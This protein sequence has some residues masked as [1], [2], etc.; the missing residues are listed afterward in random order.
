MSADEN[1]IVSGGADSLLVRWKDVTEEKKK[2]LIEEREKLVLQEQ[3]L[4]NLIHDGELLK[5]L[6]MAL[7]LQRPHQSLNIVRG[8][9]KRYLCNNLQ[10][11]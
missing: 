5:A 4:A 10:L 1:S 8:L 11:T 6:K 7:R 9:Y 2:A 3:E